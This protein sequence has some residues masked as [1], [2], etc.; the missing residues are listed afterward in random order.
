MNSDKAHQTAVEEAK[1]LLGSLA[2]TDKNLGTMT[3]YRVGGH[4]DIAESSEMLCIRPELVQEDR[5]E[6]GYLGE[7]DEA[8]ADRIFQDGFR[9]VTPNGV[10]GD[11]RG[12]S[13]E[14]GE[15]CIEQAAD[16]I[17]AFLLGRD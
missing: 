3:T 15:R 17:A 8:L 14:I 13:R 7:F 5:A 2:Q 16:G 9:S 1:R 12:M 4:A 6:A 10:L 11:A